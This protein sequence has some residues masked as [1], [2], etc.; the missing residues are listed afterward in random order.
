[1][2]LANCW[3][4]LVTSTSS[5]PDEAERRAWLVSRCLPVGHIPLLRGAP[6]CSGAGW[7]RASPRLLMHEWQL[8]PR[9]E[10]GNWLSVPHDK[11]MASMPAF[12]PAGSAHTGHSV[13][14]CVRCGSGRLRPRVETASL[15]IFAHSIGNRACGISCRRLRNCAIVDRDRHGLPRALPSADGTRGSA[16][17]KRA[18]GHQERAR[19]HRTWRG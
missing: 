12:F 4:E 9:P 5:L 15:P 19:G 2:S 13:G 7:C 11:R 17:P 14:R 8:A 10:L 3:A 6:P 18:V 1:M 16:L